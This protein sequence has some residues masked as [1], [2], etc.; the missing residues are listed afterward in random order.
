MKKLAI[1]FILATGILSGYAQET[2]TPLFEKKSG[3]GFIK[4]GANS[5]NLVQDFVKKGGGPAPSN[6]KE[7]TVQE[8]ENKTPSCVENHTGEVLF[9]N[10]TGKAIT[11]EVMPKDGGS[12]KGSIVLAANQ[13]SFVNDLGIG[14]YKYKS[15]NAKK[16]K[17]QAIILV[18]ECTMKIVQLN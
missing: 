5:D 1:L 15:P 13:S 12:V 11:L 4:K 14:M 8:V 2:S 3:G 9:F 17:K 6:S 7:G 10:N 18:R 16:Y